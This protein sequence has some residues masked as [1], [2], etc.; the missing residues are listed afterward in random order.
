[1]STLCL[2]SFTQHQ[3][4][5]RHPCCCIYGHVPLIA[6]AY[7][8]LWTLHCL[9]ILP[10]DGHLDCF[11]FGATMNKAAMDTWVQICVDVMSSFSVFDPPFFPMWPQQGPTYRRGAAWGPGEY[12]VLASGGG[13]GCFGSCHPRASGKCAGACPGIPSSPWRAAVRWETSVYLGH[14]ILACPA[15]RCGW[16][17]LDSGRPGCEPQRLLGARTARLPCKPFGP[18]L[19]PRP[20]CPP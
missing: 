16:T 17:K 19:A 18:T 5:K 7:S 1:M 3:A 20:A 14:S 12:K 15:P 6:K 4:F 13:H 8:V 2:A 10:A 11:Q 9:F